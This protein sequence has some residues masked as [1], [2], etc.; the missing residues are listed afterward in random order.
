V[1]TYFALMFAISWGVV[2]HIKSVSVA[3]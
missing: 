2:I 3:E 1:A